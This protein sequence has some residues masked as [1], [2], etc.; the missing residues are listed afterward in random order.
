M[1]SDCTFC[2]II[3]G[4][5]PASFVYKDEDVVAFMDLY[6]I[7]P[8]HTLVVPVSHHEFF[9]NIPSQVFSKMALVAQD[10]QRSYRSTDIQCEA[11]NIFL[12][13]GRLAGQEV[14]HAHLHVVPRFKGDGQ[15]MGFSHAD[16]DEAPRSELDRN[17]NKIRGAL[18]ASLWQPPAYDEKRVGIK[19]CE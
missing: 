5:L 17:S 11:S 10:I 16:P 18:E 6:P 9:E 1:T 4:E 13:N 14:P 19:I 12:S 15:R 7:T 3:S 8:G 2:K